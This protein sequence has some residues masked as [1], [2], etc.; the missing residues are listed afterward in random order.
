MLAMAF[1]GVPTETIVIAQ[2]ALQVAAEEVYQS[3]VV[4]TEME[5][6]MIGEGLDYGSKEEFIESKID[7]WMDAARNRRKQR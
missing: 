1:S 6:L 5:D 2:R 3:E 4:D 7:E